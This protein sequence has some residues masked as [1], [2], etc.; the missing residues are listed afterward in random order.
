MDMI[1]DAFPKNAGIPSYAGYQRD[2]Q[3]PHGERDRHPKTQ[4]VQ[5]GSKVQHSTLAQYSGQ[6]YHSQPGP[7][8][9]AQKTFLPAYRAENQYLSYYSSSYQHQA[10]NNIYSPTQALCEH[11]SRF[12][13]MANEIQE[14]KT[15]VEQVPKLTEQAEELRKLIRLHPVVL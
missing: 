6:Q 10:P 9:G 13:A 3:W 7:S 1:V 11:S 2:T 15:A 12:N 5:Y 14:L 8:S 4:V